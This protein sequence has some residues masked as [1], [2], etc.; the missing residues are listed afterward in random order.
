MI[1]VFWL[2]IFFALN[3]KAF[4]IGAVQVNLSYVL[5]GAK[6][7]G[8]GVVEKSEI[9]RSQSTDRICGATIWIRVERSA[10]GAKPKET[11]TVR[12]IFDVR[13]GS[14]EIGS[15]YLYVAKIRE[16]AS[17]DNL[18]DY[19][20]PDLD[21]PRDESCYRGNIDA[22]LV[23]PFTHKVNQWEGFEFIG[24]LEGEEYHGFYQV[25]EFRGVDRLY[26]NL[27]GKH[28]DAF[29]APFLY[30]LKNKEA[31]G[32]LLTTKSIFK[33]IGSEIEKKP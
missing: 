10:L 17:F 18:D 12:H 14:L 15:R 21:Q 3:S 11:F 7:I 31:I 5:D 24:T 8:I 33:L 22:Y 23:R 27:P 32:G 16:K 28:E 30:G 13:Q 6:D 20:I 9:V 25:E 1:R 2:L 4:G 29:F 19:G 26:F